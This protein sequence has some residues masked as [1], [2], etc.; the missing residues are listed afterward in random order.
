MARRG[1]SE[2]NDLDV[3]GRVLPRLS[4]R[5]LP[6]LLALALVGCARVAPADEAAHG[7]GPLPRI[8]SLNP[9][10]DAVL[11]QVADRGQILALSFYSRDPAQTSMDVAEARRFPSTDG[12][13]E[14]VV[15]LHPD[16]V[17]TS[18]YADPATLAALRSMGLRVETVGIA[19]SLAAARAQVRSL[20]AW[21]GHPERGAALLAQIDRAVAEAAPPPGHVPIP[22]VLWEP[23]GL[24]PGQHTLVS[25]LMSQ[26]GFANF[27]AQRG[28]GQSE[29]LPL[30]RM[31][32]D[33]P[34]VILAVGPAPGTIV[35][36]TGPDEDRLLFHPALAALT[37]TARAPIAPNLIY[38][39]GP[40][41]PRL[42]DRLVAVRR[43]LEGPA[44]DKALGRPQ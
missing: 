36:G 40:T 38:C 8:V 44:L 23:G 24:V 43:E 17:V 15:A 3:I 35:P 31:L 21:A 10:S 32:A 27:S 6:A 37:H 2:R 12:A 28:L 34:R 41:I 20:A 11:A 16:L 29:R 4:C 19:D 33:P 26:A 22:A 42:L 18:T 7:A 14:S 1:T 39:G 5:R 25:D 13:V 30:E 9:C